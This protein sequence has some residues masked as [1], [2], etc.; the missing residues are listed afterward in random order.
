MKKLSILSI[1]LGILFVISCTSSTSSD[2]PPTITF[3]HPQDNETI[4]D[5]IYT[6]EVSI[7]DTKSIVSVSIYVDS[8][9]LYQSPT[10][11]NYTCD[12]HTYWFTD[13]ADHIIK[14]EALDSDGKTSIKSIDVTLSDQ[15]YITPNPLTPVDNATLQYP[16]DLTWT[17]IEDAFSYEVNLVI[18]GVTFP[19]TPSTNSQTIDYTIYGAATWKVKALNALGMETRYSDEYHFTV[20]Q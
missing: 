4:N 2:N 10:N 9:C 6:I 7:E 17:A 16:I 12:W 8:I 14:V 1:F 19:L 13:S 3:I 15:A 11:K 5:S 20:N 18:N